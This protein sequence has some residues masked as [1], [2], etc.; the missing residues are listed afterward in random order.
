MKLRT[1]E[2]EETE[3]REKKARQQGT[4]IAYTLE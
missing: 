4:M 3:E 1:G 2:L